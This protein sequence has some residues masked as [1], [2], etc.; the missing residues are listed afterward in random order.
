MFSMEIPFISFKA[1]NRLIENEIYEVFKSFYNKSWYVLGEQVKLFEERYAAYNEV[2]YCVG[3]SNGLDAIFLSL[4]A[5]GIG[6][7]D[8]VIVPSNTYIATVIAII[9]VGATPVFV[10]PN[11]K[12][13]NID[14]KNIEKAI[15]LKTRCII[16]VHLYGQICDMEEINAIAA[17][18]S[19]YIIEDNAQAHGAMYKG[20][21]A[22]S[23]GTVNATSFYPTKNLGALG[24]AGAITTNDSEISKKIAM[25]RNY[26]SEVKYHNEVI[27]YNMRLDELQAGILNVKLK[28]I[29]EW[30]RQRIEIAAIY[31]EQLRDC[32][33]VIL[34]FTTENATH[35]YHVYMIRTKRRDA[36]Q[37]YLTENGIGTLIHYPIP[38]HLQK[39]CVSLSYTKGSFPIAEEIAETC[40]SLPLWPGMTRADVESVV[41]CVKNF[42][43]QK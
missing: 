29:D 30:T 10:E 13:Y 19:L 12:T 17:K 22:G 15:S 18:H 20:R 27:G 35:V 2:Q 5:L 16:P 7:G 41:R 14:T 37:K 6:S 3:L 40:L 4:K 39:A 34:P 36:L 25:L 9:N 33:D 26:G 24:D 23:W 42:F 43:A 28:Y 38:P 11:I 8:E 1:V 21:R 31:N 32:D